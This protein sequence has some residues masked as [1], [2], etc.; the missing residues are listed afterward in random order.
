MLANTPSGYGEVS[1]TEIV[2]VSSH[3][4]VPLSLWLLLIFQ[5]KLWN[6]Q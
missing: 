5:K 2:V 3:V 6:L 1:M 4:V